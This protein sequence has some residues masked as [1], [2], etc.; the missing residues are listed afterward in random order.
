MSCSKQVSR[1]RLIP[2]AST[3]ALNIALVAVLILL[4]SSSSQEAF[5]SPLEIA[6]PPIVSIA[7]QQGV[8]LLITIERIDTSN[9][10]DP[11]VNYTLKNLS[12]KP[13]RAYTVLEETAT[14]SSK[15]KNSTIKNITSTAQ[16]LLPN[17]SRQ[18][19]F[20]GQSFSDPLLSLILSID[21]VEF[22][23]GSTWGE[24]TQHAAENLAGQRAGGRETLK[25]LRGLFA[26]QGIEAVKKLIT[27]GNIE[28]VSPLVGQS[29]KWQ[30]G[31]KIGHNTILSR[32]RTAQEKGGSRQLADELQKTF[33]AAEGR[34]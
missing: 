1:R 25:K 31:F 2:V 22:A 14:S 34:P 20:G 15:V 30:Y 19:M 33:D 8:P 27:Q 23:D 26:A 11:Q 13:I 32:L 16:L 24:D 6:Q 4:R 18:E 10:L 5:S 3:A 29:E 12:D 17:Q 21:F 9:P 28:V 7:E